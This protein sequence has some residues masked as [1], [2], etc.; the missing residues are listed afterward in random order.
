MSGRAGQINTGAFFMVERFGKIQGEHDWHSRQYVDHWID[1][2]I[3]RDGLRRPLFQETLSSA[4]FSPE[5]E[6]DVLDVGAGY[7]LF[8]E[9]VLKAFPRARVTLQDYSA[10]MLEHARERLA[11]YGDKISYIKADLI[12]PAWGSKVGGPFNLAVSSLAVHNV[13]SEDLIMASYRAIYQL[14]KP[15]G[16][17]LDYDLAGLVPGGVSTHIKWLHDA[18][19]GRVELKWEESPLAIVAAWVSA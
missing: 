10:P 14:I 12:D 9:E 7:G 16:L 19:F 11:S 15:G 5:A 3:M 13:D 17:F 6:I 4:P 8:A 18:G 2:D 1:N